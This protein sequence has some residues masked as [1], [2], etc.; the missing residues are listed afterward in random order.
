MDVC[1][2]FDCHCV[3]KS[4]IGADCRCMNVEELIVAVWMYKIDCR[5]VDVRLGVDCRYVSV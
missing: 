3:E 1:I 5:C 4:Y 2:E